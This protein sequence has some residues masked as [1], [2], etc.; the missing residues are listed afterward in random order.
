MSRP[1]MTCCNPHKSIVIL[2]CFSLAFSLAILALSLVDL[3]RAS[4][5]MN[6]AV[7]ILTMAYH[8]AVFIAHRRRL[9]ISGDDHYLHPA[10]TTASLVCVYTL[11][12]LWFVPFGLIIGLG[13]TSGRNIFAGNPATV[14]TQMG[15]DSSE[16]GILV[17][18]ATTCT[19][20]RVIADRQAKVDD[21]Y[22]LANS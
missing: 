19:T 8:A 17:A 21:S 2:T 20:M 16:V 6:I 9:N 12:L 14:G 4:L 22:V 5:G 18:M 11:I 13:T 7:P 3:G 15:L 1:T 10:A